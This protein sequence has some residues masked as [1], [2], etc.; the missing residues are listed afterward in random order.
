MTE[1][2]NQKKYT[3]TKLDD[4]EDTESNIIINLKSKK[5]GNRRFMIKPK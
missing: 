4:E 3:I 2:N 1:T 5:C